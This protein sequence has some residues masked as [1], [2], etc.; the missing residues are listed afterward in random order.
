MDLLPGIVYT[1]KLLASNIYGADDAA[2]LKRAERWITENYLNFDCLNRDNI[3][4][5]HNRPAKKQIIVHFI[6]QHKVRR[7]TLLF[8]KIAS[9]AEGNTFLFAN[10]AKGTRRWLQFV[11]SKT[12]IESLETALVTLIEHEN[13][14]TV[15]IPGG[16]LT[17]ICRELS[18]KWRSN[19]QKVGGKTIH[20]ALEVFNHALSDIDAYGNK[21]TQFKSVK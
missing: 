11:S 6:N 16:A 4:D 12:D 5:E 19:K 21:D 7:N 20:I 18:R 3:C 2:A 14:N 1:T 17:T 13:K 15:I 8:V 9:N 10:D